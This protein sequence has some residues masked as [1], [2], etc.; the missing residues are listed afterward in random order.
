ME[1]FV[2]FGDRYDKYSN[3]PAGLAHI[4]EAHGTD[5]TSAGVSIN[6]IPQ[7][8]M[9]ALKTNKIVGYQGSDLGRPIYQT[10]INGNKVNIAITV[11]NNGYIVGANWLGRV[12]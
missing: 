6:E 7:T 3:K 2:F 1:R 4:I 9:Q 10:I 12:Q 8:L 5:F 11:G